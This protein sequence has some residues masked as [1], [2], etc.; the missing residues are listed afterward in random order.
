MSADT[1]K[2]ERYERFRQERARPFRDLLALVTPRPGMRVLDLGC[3]TGEPTAELHDALGAVETLGVDSSEAMLAKAA[4]RARGG[5]RFA[6]G[7]LGAF[8]SSPR[9]DLVFS[10]A[11][12]HWVPDHPALFARLAGLLAPGGQLAIQMPAN[13]DHPSHAIAARIAGEIPFRDALGGHVRE[14]PV[15]PVE[16]YAPLLHRLGSKEPLV[17]LQVYLHP[18]EGGAEDVVEWVRGSLLTDYEKRMPADLFARFV[19]RYRDALFAAL[20]DEKP[21]LYTYKRVLLHGHFTRP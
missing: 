15:L 4:L 8:V 12:V 7:D 18:L 3:G 21:F 16:E 2:P 20:P 10:N 1:W 19:A 11:A 17:R 14:S 13:E 6:K 5:L 9:W